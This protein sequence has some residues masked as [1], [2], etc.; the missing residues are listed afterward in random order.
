MT[1]VAGVRLSPREQQIAQLMAEG[2]SYG[3]I[4]VRIGWKGHNVR[5]AAHRMAS[6]LPGEGSPVVR[7][8]RW[9]YTREVAA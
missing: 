2:L 9:W 4:A 8:L 7:I 6:R 1:V 5:T 3:E